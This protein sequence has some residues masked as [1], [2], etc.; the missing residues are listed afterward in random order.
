MHLF[1]TLLQEQTTENAEFEQRREHMEAVLQEENRNLL[2]AL[3]SSYTQPLH[4]ADATRN[5]LVVNINRI[6]TGHAKLPEV[7]GNEAAV[8]LYSLLQQY[9][10]NVNWKIGQKTG[11][12]TNLVE[13]LLGESFQKEVETLGIKPA[14][15]KLKEENERVNTMLL[16]RS[17]EKSEFVHEALAKARIETD[18]AYSEITEFIEAYSKSSVT[19]SRRS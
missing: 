15:E 8:K 4:E 9:K 7:P 17:K 5:R 1:L 11:I 16:A 19:R 10:V 3:G 14:V 12:L 18:K 13:D 2:I 6:V